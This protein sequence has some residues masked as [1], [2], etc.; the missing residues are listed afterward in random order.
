MTRTALW[1]SAV[2]ALASGASARTG[3]GGDRDFEFFGALAGGGL[4][5]VGEDS[6]KADYDLG[7]GP[8][9]AGER[10]EGSRVGFDF[11][12]GVGV[13]AARGQWGVEA[14]YRQIRSRRLTPGYLAADAGAT[15]DIPE[16]GTATGFG[17]N[18]PPR[19]RGDL[20]FGQFFRRFR[21]RDGAALSIGLG[22]GYLRVSNG[23]T[24]TAS[25]LGAVSAA[26]VDFDFEETRSSPVYGGSVALTM[27]F[28]RL[29]LRPRLDAVLATRRL[30]Q[31]SD[32]DLPG[33][34]DDRGGSLRLAYAATSE[35]RPSFFLVS[36]EIALRN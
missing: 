22:G 7:L 36:L 2:L 21:V 12:W 15:P 13:R 18:G 19:S 9:S 27:E 24:L 14:A 33:V 20:Y 34:P 6:Y 10:V 23:G 16:F 29:L 8:Q 25:V 11:G 35:F 1:T 5:I 17:R 3:P 32:F 28:G 31:S 26:G 4:R 30:A